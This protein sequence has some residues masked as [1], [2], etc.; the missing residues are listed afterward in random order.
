MLG[1]HVGRAGV[2]AFQLDVE[3]GEEVGRHLEVVRMLRTA[4]HRHADERNAR[5]DRRK[6]LKQAKR[7]W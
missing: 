7:A 2:D 1:E 6:Q 5:V 3:V 4:L